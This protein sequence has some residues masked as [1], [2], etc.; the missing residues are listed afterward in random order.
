MEVLDEM[1]KRRNAS[2]AAEFWKTA[3]DEHRILE[4]AFRVCLLRILNTCSA[5]D[6]ILDEI[7]SVFRSKRIF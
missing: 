7:V 5:E 1:A 2:S 3:K 6:D 4:K